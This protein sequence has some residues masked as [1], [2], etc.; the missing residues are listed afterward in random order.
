MSIYPSIYSKHILNTII[1]IQ[2][3]YFKKEYTQKEI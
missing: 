1:D 2:K 3:K